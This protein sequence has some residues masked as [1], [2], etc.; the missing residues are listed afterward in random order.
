MRPEFISACE[1]MNVT[2]KQ[3]AS[4]ALGL[5]R[6]NLRRAVDPHAVARRFWLTAQ[7]RDRSSFA[8]LRQVAERASRTSTEALEEVKRG[9]AGRV[10]CRLFAVDHRVIRQ[11]RNALG[12]IG[13]ASGETFLI[14]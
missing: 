12:T 5:L 13:K 7:C 8:S 10:E 14:A 11:F 9:L 1:E 6:S 3:D 2:M 4:L